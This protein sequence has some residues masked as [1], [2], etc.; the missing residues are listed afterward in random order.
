MV[1]NPRRE[2]TAAVRLSILLVEDNVV[3]QKVAS[4]SLH[5][6]GYAFEVAANGLQAVNAFEQRPFDLILMDCHMPVMDGYTATQKIRACGASGR[7]VPIIAMTA[8]VVETQR[9][10]CIAAGMNDF[11]SKP[12][13]RDVLGGVLNAGWRGANSFDIAKPY[14]KPI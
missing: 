5:T 10:R 7:S 8:D 12:V 4:S 2:A 3:N 14:Y 11:L 9:E 13:K 6:L 1:Q